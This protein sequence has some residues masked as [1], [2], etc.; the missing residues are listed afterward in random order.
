MVEQLDLFGN[1]DP[2]SEVCQW[3]H[4]KYV[5]S[6]YKCSFEQ[7]M[8]YEFDSYTGSNSNVPCGYG[9]YNCTPSGMTLEKTLWSD[10]D[11]LFFKKTQIFKYLGIK[12]G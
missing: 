11:K 3:F 10:S 12:E 1:R 9:W 7:F 4:D 5:R 6:N 2:L 8:K